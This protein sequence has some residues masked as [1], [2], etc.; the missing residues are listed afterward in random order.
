[1]DAFERVTL[2]YFIN[3][4]LRCLFCFFKFTISKVRFLTIFLNEGLV[5]FPNFLRNWMVLFGIVLCIINVKTSA[6]FQVGLYLKRGDRRVR[7]FSAHN[8]WWSLR[9]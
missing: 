1:M 5:L 7:I 6:I 8:N 9:K 2:R 4:R 3:I